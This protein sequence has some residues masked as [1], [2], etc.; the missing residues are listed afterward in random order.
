MQQTKTQEKL[1]NWSQNKSKYIFD[2]DPSSKWMKSLLKTIILGPLHIGLGLFMSIKYKITEEYLD[3]ET[4][5]YLWL[6]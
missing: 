3:I 6:K 4:G 2:H 5:E 1:V